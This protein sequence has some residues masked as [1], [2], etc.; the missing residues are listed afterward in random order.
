[1]SQSEKYLFSVT[2]PA[3]KAQYLSECIDSILAQTYKN[4]EVI[5][6]NDASPQDLDSIVSRYDDPRIH[7]Y[8][9]K[10][11]FGAQHVVG[12]WNKCLEYAKGDYVICMGDDDKLLPCCL[13]EYAKLIE[14]HPSLNVYHALTEMIDENSNFLRMQ[15]MRPEREGVY[16][17]I[18]GRIKNG[19]EQYIG[20]WL[21]KADWLRSNGGYVDV[22]LAWG[23][24]DLT[25]YAAAIGK[26]VTNSQVP[27]FQ[28]RINSQ[29]ISTQGNIMVKYQARNM[30][31]QKIKELL[32]KDCPDVLDNKYRLSC[33]DIIDEKQRT[34]TAG[35][36]MSDMISNG[37]LTRFLWWLQHHNELGVPKN[38]IIK[39][40]IKTINK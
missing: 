10:V 34:S 11:G 1:M 5:I 33:L 27:M 21:F 39:A 7:Y 9:N 29:T 30:T 32:S 24:D 19:R 23:S 38:E 2:V 31:F 36:I 15:E 14:K 40:A 26:G 13:E 17:M 6:V 28:Y 35:I 4:F 3:F 25:A 16:S 8:K 12:N 22:P 18:Y 20:D 37:K